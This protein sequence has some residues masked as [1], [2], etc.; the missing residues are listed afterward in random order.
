MAAGFVWFLSLLSCAP[1]WG[2]PQDAA[3]ADGSAGREVRLHAI[4]RDS[5][6]RIVRNLEAADFAVTENGA[7][8]SVSDARFIRAGDGPIWLTL[9]FDRM[10]GEP[11]RLARE[12]AYAL[13]SEAHPGARIA[14]WAVGQGLCPLA[15]YTDDRKTIRT[16]VDAGTAKAPPAGAPPAGE[17]LS[18]IRAAERLAREG[19]FS[20][21]AASLIAVA[22]GLGA[23]QGRKAIVYFSEGLALAGP[24]DESLAAIASAA[25]LANATIYAVDATGLAITKEE[26]AA[27]AIAIS[28]RDSI[29]RQALYHPDVDAPR[30]TPSNTLDPGLGAANISEA[31]AP[32]GQ[33]ASPLELLAGK[34]GGFV[35]AQGHDVRT[36]MRRLAEELANYY[37]ISYSRPADADG[38]YRAVRVSVA[39]GKGLARVPDGFYAAAGDLGGGLLPYE[40]A[41]FDV[42]RR[43]PVSDFVAHSAVTQFRA[44]GSDRPLVSLAVEV[45]G[46]GLQFDE[47]AAAGVFHAHLSVLA[48]IRDDRGA[49][50]ERFGRD[51]PLQATPL[52]LDQMRGRRFLFQELV[53][54]PQGNYTLETAVQDRLAGHYHASRLRFAVKPAG[55]GLSLSGL[56]LVRY[57]AAAGENAQPDGA[58]QLAGKSVAPAVERVVAGGPGA[59]ITLFFRVYPAHAP[60]PVELSFEIVRDGRA[61]VRKPLRTDPADDSARVISLDVSG[62]PSGAYEVKVIATQ[63]RE[64]A[65]TGADLVIQG[66]PAA[67]TAAAQESEIAFEPAATV[68]TA[69]PDLEQRRLLDAVRLIAV[70]YT[71]RLPNF[72]CTQVT[73]RLVDEAGKD[74]WRNLDET[75]YL[76]SY[77]DGQEHYDRLTARTSGADSR[78]YPPSVTSTGEFG[79]LLKSVFQPESAAKFAWVRADAMRGHPVQV[80]SY[81]VDGEHS[82]YRVSYSMQ[83]QPRAVFS[84]FHGLVFIDQDTAVVL[85]ITQ[86]CDSLPEAFPVRQLNLSL[87]YG[88]MAVGGQVYTLPL[89]FTMDLRL[90]KRTLVRN[91][92]SFRSYQ[93]FTSDSRLLPGGE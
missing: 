11:A 47:D 41:L 29:K 51:M 74:Q 19:R 59:S 27:R 30:N 78:K 70:R 86:E 69:P 15:P 49:I 14:V 21:R 65:E 88:D 12:S 24:G 10:R 79:S 7:A 89:T 91:E 26:Q 50:V 43:A 64:R 22:R 67:E 76:V 52:L 77:Y 42:L 13:L 36:R 1:L 3:A 4:V 85:R 68:S 56:A 84:A 18:I 75:T 40:A 20:E 66:G 34:T 54:L 90:R 9:V 28:S 33:E 93:R 46:N 92:V 8:V 25:S 80:F 58:F 55:S 35:T 45:P 5:K 17:A 23:L 53:E 57:I 37:E 16:A 73:R 81:A 83:G 31:A 63:A 62:L 38:R 44:S 61:V 60:D 39:N 82:R 72:I 6:G 32:G 71:E 87:E 2:A 48:L